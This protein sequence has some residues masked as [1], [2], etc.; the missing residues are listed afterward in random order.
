MRPDAIIFAPR[1]KS[2][3]VDRSV[4]AQLTALFLEGRGRVSEDIPEP[5]RLEAHPVWSRSPMGKTRRCVTS[6]K[7]SC[8]NSKCQ[9]A[10]NPEGELKGTGVESTDNNFHPF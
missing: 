5:S 9:T 1:V 6:L 7:K 3:T 4:V 2:N 8:R 10:I